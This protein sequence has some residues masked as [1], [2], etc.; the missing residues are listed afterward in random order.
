[1]LQ[2]IKLFGNQEYEWKY[3]LSGVRVVRQKLI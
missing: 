3:F 1:V 2:M